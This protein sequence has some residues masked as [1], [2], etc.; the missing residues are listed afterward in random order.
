MIGF[1]VGL[2]MVPVVL[3]AVAMLVIVVATAF[4]TVIKR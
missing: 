3:A 2:V 1:A 4:M